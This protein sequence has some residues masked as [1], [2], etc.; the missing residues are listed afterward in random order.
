MATEERSAPCREEGG[1]SSAQLRPFD[2]QLF[3]SNQVPGGGAQV[4]G[5]ACNSSDLFTD[6]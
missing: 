4:D 6:R 3:H 1:A 5:N 2:L